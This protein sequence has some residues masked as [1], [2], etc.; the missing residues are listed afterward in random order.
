MG[1]IFQLTEKYLPQITADEVFVE[2][3]SDRWEGSTEYYANLAV[4]N[5]TV[6]HTVDIDPDPQ[7]RLAHIPGIVWHTE[8]GS[9]WSQ[10][11]FPT[12]NKKI[13][14]LYLD[15]FDYIWDINN[16]GEH[17][18]SQQQEY[19]NKF[20]LTMDNQNCQIEHFI[21][22]QY[23][24]PYMSDNSVVVLDDTYTINNCWVG[25][26]GGAVIFLLANGYTIRKTSTDCGVIL[27]R[28][29]NT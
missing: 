20:G 28:G 2:I 19:V 16:V 9:N 29:C 3:G 17:I 15:N 26:S 27:T 22:M 24:Y 18:R 12:I 4:T 1:K 23:L 6:L 11:I 25:K 7:H 21:Q 13:A 10:K 14:C 8:I 5:N